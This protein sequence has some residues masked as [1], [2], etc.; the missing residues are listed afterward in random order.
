MT[1]TT[2]AYKTQVEA[3][4]MMKDLSGMNPQQKEW[5]TR[6]QDQ[7]LRSSREV[8]K[9]SSQVAALAL[10]ATTTKLAMLSGKSKQ[11]T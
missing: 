3:E 7:K 4:V 11:N 9:S 5:L 1:S 8:E 6:R 10:E 2:S